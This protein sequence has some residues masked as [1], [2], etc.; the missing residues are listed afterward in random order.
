VNEVRSKIGSIQSRLQS[1]VNVQ[2]IFIENLTAARSRIRDTDVALEST[3][4][5]KE[6]IIEIPGVAML[7]Q[8]N[9][10]PAVALQLLRQ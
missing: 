5:A 3:N 6:T 9:Q 4:L 7:S 8:A 1:T 2:N 10:T